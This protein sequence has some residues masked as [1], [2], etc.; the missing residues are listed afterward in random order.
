MELRSGSDSDPFPAFSV[1]VRIGESVVF[2]IFG[3]RFRF[4]FLISDSV[5]VGKWRELRPRFVENEFLRV[6]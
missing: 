4:F 1:P 3:I 5:F 2:Q 6:V